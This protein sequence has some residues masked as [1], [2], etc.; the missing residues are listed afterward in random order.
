MHPLALASRG[1]NAGTSQIGQVTRN[2]GL[3]LPENLD[4]VANAHFSA[5]H[6]VQQPESGAI[7]ECGE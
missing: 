4:K 3:A 2:L 7:R 1:N 5:A 6:Q